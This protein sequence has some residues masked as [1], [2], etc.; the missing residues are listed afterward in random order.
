MDRRRFERQEKSA[1]EHHR[2]HPRAR[3][4]QESEARESQASEETEGKRL[5]AE[6]AAAEHNQGAVLIQLAVR[7][8]QFAVRSSQLAATK[9]RVILSRRS[10]RSAAKDLPTQWRPAPCSLEGPSP[11]TRLRMTPLVGLLRAVSC[12]CEPR[13][14]IC[15][16]PPILFVTKAEVARQSARQPGNGKHSTECVHR[17]DVTLGRIE[18]PAERRDT[19]L[20][21]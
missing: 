20:E 8:S 13:S 2:R 21:Q 18:D 9:R 15:E 17:G 19:G 6:Q 1:P 5:Q 7:S 16:L 4:L 11:S 10:L 3:R 14:A 12:E